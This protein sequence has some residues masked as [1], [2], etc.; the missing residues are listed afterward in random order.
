MRGV[1][2]FH[3]GCGCF[4]CGF[5]GGY[6]F[7]WVCMGVYTADHYSMGRCE[8]FPDEYFEDLGMNREMYYDAFMGVRAW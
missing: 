5:A 8:Q 6:E 4:I 2:L 1:T 3:R 7:C